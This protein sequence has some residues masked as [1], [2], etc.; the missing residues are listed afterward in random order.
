MREKQRFHLF[1]NNFSN[2]CMTVNKIKI[3]AIDI[4]IIMCYNEFVQ[5]NGN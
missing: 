3:K 1:T 5:N 2:N 4:K